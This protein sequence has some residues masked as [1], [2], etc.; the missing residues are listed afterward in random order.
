MMI[1]VQNYF[2]LMTC[3]KIQIPPLPPANHNVSFSLEVSWS[4]D[5][6]TYCLLTSEW[7]KCLNDTF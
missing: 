6:C 5:V 3:K 1:D 4:C 7:E 2:S